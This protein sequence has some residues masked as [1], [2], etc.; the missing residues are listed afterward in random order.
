METSFENGIPEQFFWFNEPQ[1]HRTADGALEIDTRRDTDFWQTTHYGFNRD[2]GHCLFAK[3]D[4]NFSMTVRTEFSYQ[5]QYDQCGLFVRVDEKNWIKVSVE[6]EDDRLNRLGSVVTN[7]GFSD[8][9][10]K[11]IEEPV[12]NMWY[13]I[14]SSGADFLIESSIDE[15]TWKQMRLA[16]LHKPFTSLDIGVYACSPKESSFTAKFS[17]LVIGESSWT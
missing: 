6:R 13:R 15:T 2:S 1:H 11:D 17:N 7:L 9:A 14:Q 4:F 8:W 3:V 12:Y 16:H 5:E 10:T